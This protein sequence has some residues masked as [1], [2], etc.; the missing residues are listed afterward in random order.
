MFQS[1]ID[2]DA[3][4][5]QFTVANEQSQAPVG[6]ASKHKFTNLFS[7]IR[8]VNARGI[9]SHAFGGPSF[10]LPLSPLRRL[11]LLCH[12]VAP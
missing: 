4:G 8:L 1:P 2:A 6:F 5:P 7:S 11:Y 12:A 3:A 10:A 9:H